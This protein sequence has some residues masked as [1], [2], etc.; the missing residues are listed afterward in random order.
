LFN[1]GV[2]E[3]NMLFRA[4]AIFG[5][6][7]HHANFIVF[8]GGAAFLLALAGYNYRKFKFNSFVR[9]D[10]SWPSTTRYLAKLVRPYLAVVGLYFIWKGTF[11]WDTLLL[12]SVT[13]GNHAASI[14]PLWFIQVLVQAVVLIAVIFSIPAMRSAAKEQGW[15]MALLLFA[16]ST[17]LT[18][19][20]RAYPDLP[21]IGGE[22]TL[23]RWFSLVFLGWLACEARSALKKAV[24]VVISIVYSLYFYEFTSTTYWIMVGFSATVLVGSLPAPQAIAVLANN[25]ARASYYIYLSHIATFH[26]V[27]VALPIDTPAV[28]TAVAMFFGWLAW[29]VVDDKRAF[30]L[31]IGTLRNGFGRSVERANLT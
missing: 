15:T 23:G 30:H 31:V 21:L 18:L 26:I 13:L 3:T 8:P 5:V 17:A 19:I 29:Y 11:E 10:S 22:L 25:V 28:R 12:V 16:A 14:F 27:S 4:L 20:N 7:A 1:R 6:V 2:L 9:D 24:F